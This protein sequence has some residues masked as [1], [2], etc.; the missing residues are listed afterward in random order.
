MEGGVGESWG[1]NYVGERGEKRWKAISYTC[2]RWQS[3]WNS[4][5]MTQ[6][7]KEGFQFFIK[8]VKNEREAKSSDISFLRRLSWND[9]NGFDFIGRLELEVFGNIIG[10]ILK[11]YLSAI[12]WELK[13]RISCLN[14]WRRRKFVLI[15]RVESPDR[16]S[17]V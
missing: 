13:F 9:E 3:L 5:I 12:S 16:K 10:W 4:M 2:S 14:K 11:T 15:S 1:I 7:D 8:V 17:V 6:T